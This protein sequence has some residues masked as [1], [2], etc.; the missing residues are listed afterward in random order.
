MS[1]SGA[2]FREAREAIQETHQH[3]LTFQSSMGNKNGSEDYF[4]QH[5][6]PS[7]DT[8]SHAIRAA[9]GLKENQNQSDA[10]LL[11]MNDKMR[12]SLY[13][14]EQL[15]AGSKLPGN[16]E[17]ETGK[18]IKSAEALLGEVNKKSGGSRKHRKRTH[19]NRKNKRTHRN[20][21]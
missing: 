1:N 19:R 18:A 21:K 2:F 6:R 3:L 11:Q 10:E 5:V 15:M 12:Y 8:F 4:K 14:I 9:V 16:I 20:R 17:Y 13:K 7:A